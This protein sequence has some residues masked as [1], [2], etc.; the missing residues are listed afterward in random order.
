M[1]IDKYWLERRDHLFVT[2]E[3]ELVKTVGILES[4]LKAEIGAEF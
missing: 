3:E 2:C 4:L 1:N